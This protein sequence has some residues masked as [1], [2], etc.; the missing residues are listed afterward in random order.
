MGLQT[1]GS[2]LV[3]EKRAELPVVEAQGMRRCFEQILRLLNPYNRGYFRVT[4]CSRELF[5]ASQQ[6]DLRASSR[7][8]CR[9]TLPRRQSPMVCKHAFYLES[10][11]PA[12]Q[13]LLTLWQHFEIC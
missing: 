11:Q 2:N 9:V 12:W 3:T 7:E 13:R 10:H 4:A 5:R 1:D 6:P 8:Y